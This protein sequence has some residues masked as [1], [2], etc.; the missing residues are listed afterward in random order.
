MRL[1]CGAFLP[2]LIRTAN[3]D[4][5]YQLLMCHFLGLPL[6]T[7]RGLVQHTASLN[8]LRWSDGEWT[9]AQLKSTWLVSSRTWP[10]PCADVMMMRAS[11]SLAS[12]LRRRTTS[13]PRLRAVRH[14]ERSRRADSRRRF[15]W[16]FRRWSRLR[17]LSSAWF[18]MEPSPYASTLHL[19]VQSWS[20][21]AASRKSRVVIWP[22]SWLHSCT[23]T[24][25]QRTW[26]SG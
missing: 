26:R 12:F 19:G 22:T 11:L 20:S 14:R 9:V 17:N 3:A 18:S 15:P 8:Q 2:E 1:R 7:Y 13:S 21:A 6:L 24:L 10:D 23:V 4:G 16:R 5:L 25:P